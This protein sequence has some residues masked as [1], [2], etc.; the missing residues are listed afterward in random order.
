[1]TN[2]HNVLTNTL[3]QFLILLTMYPSSADLIDSN[4]SLEDA[5][6]AK[7]EISAILEEETSNVC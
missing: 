7:W 3:E 1:M 4:V 5:Y 2:F 6:K